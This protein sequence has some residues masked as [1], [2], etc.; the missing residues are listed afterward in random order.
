MELKLGLGLRKR[1][2]SA[3]HRVSGALLS[4]LPLFRREH[5]DSFDIIEV[6]FLAAALESANFYQEHMLMPWRKLHSTE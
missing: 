6:A 4:G 5:G 3:I 1:A 2:K